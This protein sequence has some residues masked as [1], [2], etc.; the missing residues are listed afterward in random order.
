MGLCK[1]LCVDLRYLCMGDSKYCDLGEDIERQCCSVWI[2]KLIDM[3]GD[4]N[5][6]ELVE[7]HH[8]DMNFP[9]IVKVT[10]YVRSH[11]KGGFA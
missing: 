9:K 7:Q 4:S 1:S 3:V 6:L 11:F 10:V 2:D 5:R 8:S